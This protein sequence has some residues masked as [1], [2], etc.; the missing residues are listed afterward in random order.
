MKRG[1]AADLARECKL[2][3][4][5]ISRIVTRTGAQPSLETILDVTEAVIK[6]QK[7]Q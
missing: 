6:L 1:N 5:T 3:T 2:P 7:M 4:S